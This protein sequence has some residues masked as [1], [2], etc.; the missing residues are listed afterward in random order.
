MPLAVRT[1]VRG[2]D[3]LSPP[4][5]LALTVLVLCQALFL[6]H[7]AAFWPALYS[8]DSFTYVWQVSTGNWVSDHSIAYDSLVWLSLRV[9]GNLWLLTLLQTVFASVL[10]AD[11]AVSLHRIGVRAR[12]TVAASAI[13]VLLPSTGT[14]FVFVWKDVPYVL[15]AVL[16]FSGCVRLAGL[17][18]DRTVA[19]PA[20]W[21]ITVGFAAVLVFRNNGYP[22]IVVVV[23]GILL[24]V[25]G[26]RLRILVAGVSTTLIALLLTLVVYPSVGVR[27]P[28]KDAVIGLNVADIAVSYKESPSSF[29]SAD[30]AVMEA[31]AP[32]S[33]WRGRAANC[34]DADWA[35]AKPMN[36]PAVTANSSALLS[37]W[38]RVLLRTPQDIV[39]ARLCRAQI[40]WGVTQGPAALA[41]S[42]NVKV[43]WVTPSMMRWTYDHAN[44][45]YHGTRITQSPYWR[46]LQKQHPLSDRL[47]RLER[48][49]S[50]RS[51]AV[52][53][54]WIVW[55]GAIWCYLCYALVLRLARVRRG[56][57]WLVLLLPTLSL[58]LTV[59][60][61]NPAQIWRY[62]TGPLVI[63]VL[64]LPLATLTR[65]RDRAFAE[66]LPPAPGVEHHA[67]PEHEIIAAGQAGG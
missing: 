49:Y 66:R 65:S 42:T 7:W 58:Q 15:G 20:L 57:V 21:R 10:M 27:L 36:R 14:F 32:L 55:R 16:V 9:T 3:R 24:L 60:A 6:V 28:H 11:T 38:T 62:M 33:H 44:W 56:K 63:G 18:A 30:L 61:A 64:A 8:P 48:T 52:S 50:T 4:R 40:A 12:W 51:T 31:V 1:V 53:T 67:P 19:R 39:G 35:M 26:V 34:W 29:S 45:S 43:P 5:R 47:N 59:I 37:L 23:A 54:Q 46:V 2:R 13:V 22:A 41:G 25:P 17:G